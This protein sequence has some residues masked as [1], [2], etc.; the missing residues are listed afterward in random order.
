MTIGQI[1]LQAMMTVGLQAMMTVGLLQVMMIGGPQEIVV[2]SP[3]AQTAAL[4]P[5]ETTAW[6]VV[7]IV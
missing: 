5:P 1:G 6:T 4:E 3:F 7:S 2:G